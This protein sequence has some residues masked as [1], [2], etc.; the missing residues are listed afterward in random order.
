VTSISP[1]RLIGAAR[2]GLRDLATLVTFFSRLPV[3]GGPHDDIAQLSRA[4][5]LLPLAGVVVAVPAIVVV[6]VFGASDLPHLATATLA[7]AALALSTGF[8]HEDGLS[9]T[10]DGLLG[11]ADRERRLEIMRDSRIGAFGAAALVLTL[12]LRVTLLAAALDRFGVF[13]AVL[14]VAATAAVSRAG[15]VLFWLG[16]PAARGD[17]LSAT[18]GQPTARASLTALGIAAVVSLAF[19]AGF[20]GFWLVVL[21]WVMIGLLV[22]VLSVVAD[23]RIGGQTGDVLGAMQQLAEIVFLIGILL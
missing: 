7:V 4:I 13:G 9:D 22:I 15:M 20:S 21:A 17:G 3:P 6:L 2:S 12:M 23:I 19:V 14:V 1:E 18:I 5:G 8:L 16:L 11:G 10:A